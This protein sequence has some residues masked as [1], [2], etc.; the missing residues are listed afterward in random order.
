MNAVTLPVDFKD[1][2]NAQILAISEDRV[3]GFQRDPMG[4]IARLSEVPVETV[5]PAA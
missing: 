5:S 1:P 3:Q 2:V 4:E